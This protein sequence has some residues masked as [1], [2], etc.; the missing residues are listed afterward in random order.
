[1]HS[2][3]ETAPACVTPKSMPAIFSVAVRGAELVL[4]LAVN[5]TC[6][7]PLPVLS[8]V[9]SSHDSELCAVHWQ[10][11]GAMTSTDPEPPADPRAALEAD[12]E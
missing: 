6:P 5:R 4:G 11:P 3:V 10:S 8:D 12:P 7:R 1:M 9:T 2:G